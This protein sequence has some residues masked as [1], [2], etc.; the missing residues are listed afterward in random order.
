MTEF[1]ITVILAYCVI[2]I[3]ICHA[4]LPKKDVYATVPQLLSKNGYPVEKHRVKTDDGYILQVHRI[5]A[6]R[7]FA[8]RSGTPG[9]KGKKAVLVVHGLLGSSGD[10]VV[11]GPQSSLSYI[12][13]DGGYDVWL[14]NL[15]GNMYTT[16]ENLTRNDEVF[17]NYSFHEHG[18]YDI[19]A[20]IETVL[21]VTGLSKILYIGYSMGTTS[22]FTMM[23]QRPEYNDKLI[24]FVA[25]APAVYLD[26]IKPMASFLLKSIDIVNT[27]RQQG[28]MSAEFR[29]DIKDFVAGSVCSAKHAQYDVCMRMI[30]SIVGEDY[31][32][33]VWDMTSV[34]VTRMQPASWKQLE[35]F[36][37]IAI[38]GTF[39]QWEDGLWGAVKP[40]NLSNVRIPV[41]I[42][43][44]ENDQLTEKS[45]ILRLAKELNDTGTLYSIKPGCSWPK[46]NHLDFIFA[47]DVGK[48][49]NKP[50]ITHLDE[51][52]NKFH[53]E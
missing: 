11:M 41:S 36:G 5:P 47:R 39:T 15:R 44:G 49:V 17:W 20:I 48:L 32:Q 1:K 7:R 10:F 34:I 4:Q 53:K 26:N 52:Y 18:K 23:S 38:T 13:A 12:L 29:R 31:E 40:Y 14:A 43:Y 19:P 3:C 25:L 46:F 8:R 42:R 45:Q 27:L 6:G 50:L 21:N 24:A 22:F 16:H 2:V 28:M 51:L 30:F 37:K 33:H 35:H 9:G